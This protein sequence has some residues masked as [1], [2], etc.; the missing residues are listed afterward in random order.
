M[1]N[2]EGATFGT[3]CGENKVSDTSLSHLYHNIYYQFY[4]YCTEVKLT[5]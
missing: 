3:P 4:I 1:T 5:A 2:Y